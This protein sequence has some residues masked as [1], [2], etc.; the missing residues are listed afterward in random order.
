LGNKAF[1]TKLILT[2]LEEDILLHGSQAGN[3]ENS[4]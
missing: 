4:I 1:E 2:W 3:L